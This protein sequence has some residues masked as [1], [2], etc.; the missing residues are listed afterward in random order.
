MTWWYVPWK[1]EEEG[2]RHEETQQGQGSI[3][4][5]EG[6]WGGQRGRR[7]PCSD[8]KKDKSPLED[9]DRERDKRATDTLPL[10]ADSST[11][12]ALLRKIA[13][14]F[15]KP[16]LSPR[17]FHNYNNNNLAEPANRCP[18]E[19][20]NINNNN[21][22]TMTPKGCRMTSFKNTTLTCR[23]IPQPS[24]LHRH[25]V[26][27][28]FHTTDQDGRFPWANE[29]ASATFLLGW[30][31]SRARALSLSLARKIF[32]HQDFQ[33]THCLHKNPY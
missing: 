26:G 12:L 15:T 21:N 5:S 3:R 30:K 28:L 31:V 2:A 33:E 1:E 23:N 22:R 27:L 10:L 32:N 11:L 8:I 18:V 6:K 7:S 4:D 17:I 16:W 19:C 13:Q 29:C 20:N 14:V 24:G 9:R 25:N